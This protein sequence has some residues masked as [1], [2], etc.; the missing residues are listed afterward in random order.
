MNLRDF[1]RSRDYPIVIGTTYSFDPIFFEKVILRDLRFGYAHSIIIMA[2][3][4]QAIPAISSKQGQLAHLGKSYLVEPINI[5]GAFH[6]KVLLKI[7]IHG[8]RIA[9]GSGNMTAG[10]WG[11][12]GEL[13]SEIIADQENPGNIPIVLALLEGLEQYSTDKHAK[14]LIT[15]AKDFRWIQ[16][17][18]RTEKGRFLLTPATQSLANLLMSEWQGKQFE[19][20]TIYTGSTDENG[21]FLD[22]CHQK[23]GV[24]EFLICANADHIS[25]HKQKLISKPYSVAFNTPQSSNYLHAKFYLF[26]SSSTSCAIMGSANCS[27]AA[28]LLSPHEG[29][30]VEAV[31]LFEDT[32]RHEY[33]DV[34]KIISPKNIELNDYQEPQVSSVDER[35]NN[36]D[37]LYIKNVHYDSSQQRISI[38]LFRSLDTS[39]SMQ[40]IV[41][42]Q[43]LDLERIDDSGRIWA[44]SIDGLPENIYSDFVEILI[45]DNEVKHHAIHW[46]NH[47]TKLRDT[48]KAKRISDVVGQM[49]QQLNLSRQYEV[50][51][52]LVDIQSV[53]IDQ[54]TAFPDP[55]PQHSREDHHQG[56]SNKPSKHAILT[57]E[58][59]FR[60]L[61]E[62]EIQAN[63]N[64]PQSQSSRYSSVPI[65][66]IPRVFFSDLFSELNESTEDEDVDKEFDGFEDGKPEDEKNGEDQDSDENNDDPNSD[67]EPNNIKDML[68]EVKLQKFVNEMY[69]FLTKIR[70]EKFLN[71][72]S[73]AQLVQAAT[74]PLTVAVVGKRHNW[75]KKDIA[76]DLILL[77]LNILFREKSGDFV[78]IIS[79]VRYRFE[80]KNL[81]PVFNEAIGDGDLWLTILTALREIEW[82]GIEGLLNQAV[83][84]KNISRRNYLT[85][86]SHAPRIFKLLKLHRY[87]DTKEWIENNVQLAL[88]F[89][90]KV[91]PHLKK[92]ISEYI[93]NQRHY[94]HCRGDLV[95]GKLGWGSV[96]DEKVESQGGTRNMH[97]YFHE[98][99]A[100]KVVMATGFFVNI[101]FILSYD[102]ELHNLIN[103]LANKNHFVTSKALLET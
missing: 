52:D 46:V 54:S 42:D 9:F 38:M 69:K 6:P 88:D 66:G 100:V 101:R 23:F 98:R 41:N 67:E 61:A 45:C 85:A 43:D 60:S 27:R 102:H 91:E 87:P 21:A 63:S 18:N 57:T 78:G 5:R 58:D 22:W 13:Y 1:C 59:L 47:Q 99:D 25:F 65:F 62:L 56:H 92:N 50:L 29:G 40:I 49:A 14:Q 71:S 76:D 97:I 95:Y 4:S 68:D 48:K 79:A 16:N 83:A 34:L 24:N 20:M 90:N 55:I 84:I 19:K 81:L 17:A 31:S 10:G 32:T 15:R 70:E 103:D 35:S 89:L 93:D 64:S 2:D 28:W 77:T 8:A 73:A 72:C 53:L 44:T 12:N 3:A 7:G 37:M 80:Q 96:L 36:S 82:Q 94:E 11:E 26:E 39:G 33:E 75:I 30:N 74:Y 51:K 86:N